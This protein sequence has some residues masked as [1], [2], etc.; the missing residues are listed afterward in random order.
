ME[1][2]TVVVEASSELEDGPCTLPGAPAGYGGEMAPSMEW[3]HCCSDA[4]Y[5]DLRQAD[6][7]Q[8]L[9]TFLELGP[10]DSASNE[11]SV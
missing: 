6:E 10:R 5:H 11:R 7:D 4:V 3:S 2:D 8:A 9:G 1:H